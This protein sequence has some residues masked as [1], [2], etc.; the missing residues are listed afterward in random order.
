M[1]SARYAD[2]VAFLENIYHVYSIY[3]EHKKP[4]KHGY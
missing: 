4:H 3:M 2:V 1:I